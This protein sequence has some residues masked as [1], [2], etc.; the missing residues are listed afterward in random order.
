MTKR[1]LSS[2][3][4]YASLVS[5][6]LFIFSCKEI[7][8]TPATSQLPVSQHL[9]L[10]NPSQAVASVSGSNNYLMVKKEYALSYSR[11]RGNANW[12]SWHVSKDW[13]GDAPRQDDFRADAALPSDWYKVTTSVYTGTG[14]D[15]GHNIP[16][17]D[18]TNTI[19]A[20]S[21]T[22]LMTNILPQAPTHNRELWSN[23]EE[24]T[25][26]LVNA[27][28]EVYVIMGSYGTGGTGSNGP[29]TTIAN[30]RVTV[31][32][33]IWKVLVVLPDGDK[34][35][36]RITTATRVIAIN[37]PNNNTVRSDWGTYRTNID[38]IEANTGYD[39]LSVLPKQLQAVLESKVDN[40]PT[41]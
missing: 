9:V 28:Q 32:A 36:E 21:A 6:A 1:S 18:R 35:L 23:L 19:E 16:S 8:V 10:G 20:N 34:D 26:Q 33:Q 31:P 7:Q 27:G 4:K 13:L 17:G 37:T 30:G 38:L 11:D 41:N 29:A 25:R 14:F 24:Y 15:R 3:K 5:L 12:V 39:L 2:L 40:G 22:F